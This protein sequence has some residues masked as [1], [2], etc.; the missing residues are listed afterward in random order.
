MTTRTR[1][2]ALSA[3]LAVLVLALA[4]CG[5]SDEPSAT[6]T[7]APTETT[8]ATTTMAGETTTTAAQ[9]E[10]VTITMSAWDLDRTPEF[11]LLADRFH[12]INPSVTVELKEY[13]AGSEYDTQLTADLAAGTAPDVYV[14]KN[15]RNFAIYQEGGQLAD[16]SDIVADVGAGNS[17]IDFY[18]VDGAVW[19]VPYR[20]DTWFLYYNKDL[21]D[22]AG[23][24]YPTGAITWDEYADLAEQITTGLGGD[25]VGSYEHG[26][27]STLQGFA[28]AQSPGADILSGIYDYMAPYYERVLAMQDNGSQ[29]DYAT[30][31]TNSLTYQGQFGTQKAAMMNMG[32]W[33]VATLISQQESGDADT[34]EWGIAP[35]PQLDSST[36]DVPVS[37]GDPTGLG[38]NPAIDPGKLDAAKAFL[39]FVGSEDAATLLAGIGI[40]PAYV[41]DAVTAAYFAGA[42]VPQDDLSKFAFGT[43]DTRPENPVSVDTAAIQSILND[44]HSAILTNSVSVTDGIAEAESRALSEVLN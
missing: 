20:Q 19:A 40:K 22:Q 38:I 5:S 18:T 44:M 31:T 33:Y 35:A 34:F 26:W 14:L 37:F 39:A 25:I 13:Q 8:A 10:P 23:V 36:F 42:G 21:F 11:Q 27:Q 32:S 29:T 12:E 24:D 2:G 17:A 15:L 28:N 1:M 41:S 3:A 30:V 6:T 43:H 9:M 16:V 7:T 4:G